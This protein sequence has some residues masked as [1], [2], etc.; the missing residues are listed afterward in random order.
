MAS[1]RWDPFRDLISIQERMAKL[2]DES[3]GMGSELR[4]IGRGE[5]TPRVDVTET[6]NAIV[7]H[8]ELAGV[9]LSDISVEVKQNQL[10]IHGLRRLEK[11]IAEENFIRL[12]RT[13]GRF[14]RSFNLPGDVDSD[15]VHARILDGVLEIILPKTSKSHRME[16]EVS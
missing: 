8:A 3:F 2:F 6:D 1:S 9:Q 14:Y 16:I 11:N 5:W 4:T 13:H 7:V 15:A 12:E 10:V